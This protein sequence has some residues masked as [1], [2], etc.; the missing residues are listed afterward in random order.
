MAK[1]YERI[2][3]IAVTADESDDTLVATAVKYYR[4]RG[5]LN[6]ADGKTVTFVAGATAANHEVTLGEVIPTP[7]VIRLVSTF[8]A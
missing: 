2:L 1:A 5:K 4:D 6:A 8:Q 3:E 7:S